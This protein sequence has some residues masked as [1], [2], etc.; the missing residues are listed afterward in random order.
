MTQDGIRKIPGQFKETQRCAF[1]RQLFVG[2]NAL[3]LRRRQGLLDVERFAD[4]CVAPDVEA[5][6]SAIDNARCPVDDGLL[7]LPVTVNVLPICLFH[8]PLLDMRKP[9]KLENVCS[10]F[11][12]S[13]L[14]P[15]V[16]LRRSL[17]VVRDSL[18]SA[19]V[20]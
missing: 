13:S 6:V 7:L 20:P 3:F 19:Q 14:T 18:I 11:R 8:R 15:D 4:A 5:V 16:S 9:G 10:T 2:A 17:G 1:P 12:V